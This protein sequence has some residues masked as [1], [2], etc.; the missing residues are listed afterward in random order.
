MAITIYLIGV[1]LHS[2]TGL[3]APVGMLL[4]AVLLEAREHHSARASKR[5]RGSSSASLWLPSPIR[6]CLRWRLR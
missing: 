2:F 3:P 6:C 4:V 1:L 5:A